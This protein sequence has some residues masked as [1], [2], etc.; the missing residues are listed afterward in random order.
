MPDCRPAGYGD[1]GCLHRRKPCGPSSSPRLQRPMA[2]A[3]LAATES[4]TGRSA[5]LQELAVT[6]STWGPE[7]RET[8]PVRGK[9]ADARPRVRGTWPLCVVHYGQPA[10]YEFVKQMKSATFRT[11]GTVEPSQLAYESPA[12]YLV[13]KQMKSATLRIGGIEEPS[14]LA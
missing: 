7:P 1:T 2:A 8:W 4:P 14:Q 9:R 5:A 11:G 10:A 6:R 13:W 12:A 3:G